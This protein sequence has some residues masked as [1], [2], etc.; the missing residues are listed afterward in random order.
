MTFVAKPKVEDTA[1]QWLARAN[2]DP[3]DPHSAD[4]IAQALMLAL[5]LA[6]FT[7]SPS[8]STA[9]PGWSGAAV[10]PTERNEPHWRPSGRRVS[11]SCASALSLA[12][13]F[14]WPRT[15]RRVKHCRFSIAPFRLQPR[16]WPWP[17]GFVRFRAEFLRPLVR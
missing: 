2:L 1:H 5:E 8:G 7:P 17:H 6:T 14:C 10:L 13:E 15:W 4:T 11:G 3:D 16:G 12:M 9:V